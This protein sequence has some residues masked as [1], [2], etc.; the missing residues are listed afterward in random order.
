MKTNLAFACLS[1]LLWTSVN[2]FFGSMWP[3][4][5]FLFVTYFVKTQSLYLIEEE[6][7]KWVLVH[8]FALDS[9]SKK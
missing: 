7:R 3:S 4:L 1:S 5:F 2:A 8:L 9:Y 6:I